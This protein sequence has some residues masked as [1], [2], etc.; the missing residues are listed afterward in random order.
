MDFW[1]I[2]L[3]SSTIYDRVIKLN[4]KQHTTQIFPCFPQLESNSLAAKTNDEGKLPYL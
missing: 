3:T 1:Q 2:I 4:N